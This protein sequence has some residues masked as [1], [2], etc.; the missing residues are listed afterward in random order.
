MSA[1]LRRIRSILDRIQAKLSFRDWKDYD[2]FNSTQGLGRVALVATVLGGMLGV[3]L[4]LCFQL[5]LHV[6]HVFPF[7]LGKYVSSP[8][9]WMLWQWAA[10]FSLVCLFHLLEFFVT[11][12]WN[13]TQASAQSFLVDHSIAYTAA[14]LTSWLEFG[15]RFLFFPSYNLVWASLFGLAL[16]LTA[17]GIRS[18]AMKTASESFNHYIQVKKKDN[19]VLIT[20]GI[21]AL[22]RHPSYVGFFYWSI[23]T[24]L[25]LGNPIHALLYAIVSWSFFRRRIAYEEESLVQLF[26]DE[27]PAYRRR[28]W[29][30]IPFLK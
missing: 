25:V 12:V 30:G 14:A 9:M 21:Y 19:H 23:A 2:K 3:H 5:S 6:T 29:M 16:A 20:H 24:Q 22:W 7:Y 13:P 1:L 17:Q 15:L 27:Y 28:T 4:L 11:A 18:L 26:P 8:R 10:Y